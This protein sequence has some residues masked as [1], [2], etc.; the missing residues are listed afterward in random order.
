VGTPAK[1][2]NQKNKE[3][4]FF[5]KRRLMSFKKWSYANILFSADLKTVMQ[6]NKNKKIWEDIAT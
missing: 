3:N 5:K 2:L 1:W 4:R 6:I